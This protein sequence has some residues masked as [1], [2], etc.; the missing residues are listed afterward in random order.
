MMQ[1]VPTLKKLLRVK[2]IWRWPKLAQVLMFDVG[3]NQVMDEELG[4]LLHPLVVEGMPLL[5]ISLNVPVFLVSLLNGVS[6]TAYF[7]CYI[8]AVQPRLIITYIDNSV[9]FYSY[10]V[11]NPQVKTLFIQNGIRGYGLDVFEILYRKPTGVIYQVDYMM[12]FGKLVGDEYARYISGKVVPIGSFINNLVPVRRQKV[13]GT[14]A[15]ISQYRDTSGFYM[16]GVFYSF[17][18]YWEQSDRLVIPFL[19]EYA[20][21]H[22]KTFYIVPCTGGLNDPALQEKEKSYYN[23]IAGCEC[24]YSDWQWHGSSY[25][26]ID[27]TEVVVA[28]DSSMG[29]ESM[30]RGTK[31]AIFS[32]RATNFPLINASYHNYGWPGNYPDDGPFWTN[33]T[34][35]TA[36]G[37]ILDHLFAVGDEEW[38]AELQL[39]RFSDVMQY[40]PG[41][42]ILRGILESELGIVTDLR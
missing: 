7:D 10:S 3:R 29:L 16:G 33:R 22:G 8:A 6:R 25:D 18:K 12:T 40:D 27:A 20:K 26:M 23:R 5:I 32:I 15:F 28:I 37:R 17:E 9:L 38:R 41:N 2:W 39:E 34:D 19:L 13:K 4:N 21:A 42:S 11:R 36:F 24:S 30:A 1:I 35:H 31:A 14:L